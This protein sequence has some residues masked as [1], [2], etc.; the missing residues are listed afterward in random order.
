MVEKKN[1]KTVINEQIWQKTLEKGSKK[2]NRINISKLHE[3]M[4]R[5][6]DKKIGL[7]DISRR[8]YENGKD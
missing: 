1:D 5:V 6:Q 7:K 8:K 3:N 4:K 2:L